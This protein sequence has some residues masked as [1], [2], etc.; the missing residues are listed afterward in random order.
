MTDRLKEVPYLPR[1]LPFLGHLPGM[2]CDPFG[3]FDRA[4]RYGPLVRVRLGPK[5]ACVVNDP[6]LLRHMLVAG[7][8][9]FDKGGGVVEAFI[10]L[11]GGNGGLAACP[12][13]AHRVA[14]PLMQPAFHPSRIPDY[15][16]QMV[17]NA[18]EIVGRWRPGQVVDIDREMTRLTT[19]TLTNSLFTDP[20]SVRCVDQF[21]HDLPIISSGLLART[22]LP[23]YGRLP[24]PANRRYREAQARTR[25]AID[26]MIRHRREDPGDYE[27][28]FSLL[29]V[30]GP[31]GT[32]ALSDEEVQGH[33]WS[34]M[35]GGIDT[36]AALLAWTLSLLVRH[37]HWYTRVEKEIDTALDGA[38]PSHADLARLPQLQ[39]VLTETL[40]LYPPGWVVSR[41]TRARTALGGYRIPEGAELYF[42]I[43]TLLRDPTIYA[44][45]DRFDPDRW[46]QGSCTREQREAYLPFG[47]GARKCIG[48]AFAL[49]EAASTLAV[50]LQRWRVQPVA[51]SQATLKVGVVLHPKGLRLRVT[52]RTPPRPLRSETEDPVPARGQEGSTGTPHETGQSS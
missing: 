37:P 51:G 50:L 8:G 1:K 41:V 5:T 4:A 31:D 15:N 11:W 43:R 9:D 35:I 34:F 18:T 39:R 38:P 30:R 28:L 13:E 40:R 21:Q 26:S 32:V 29:L 49:A 10:K 45:P 19:K 33:I 42:S 23:A 3:F 6:A 25:S 24:L 52:P 22:I 16:R 46:L 17:H 47:A 2:A 48:D 12:N 14:R 27:D 20:V 36:T 7:R 44:D